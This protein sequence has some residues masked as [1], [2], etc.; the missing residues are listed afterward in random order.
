MRLSRGHH[1]RCRACLFLCK[2]RLGLSLCARRRAWV[3]PSHGS[4]PDDPLLFPVFGHISRC[5]CD[6]NLYVRVTV[7]LSCVGH[8]AVVEQ[9]MNILSVPSTMMLARPLCHGFAANLDAPNMAALSAPVSRAT[10][11]REEVQPG[12]E[13][14]PARCVCIC[15]PQCAA[16]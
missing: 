2:L 6:L 1:H 8:R 15:H 11:C 9:S 14:A 5:E 4:C 16:S 3:R 10:G 12:E 7:D 13:F